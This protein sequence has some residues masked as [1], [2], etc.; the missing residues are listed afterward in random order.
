MLSATL[1]TFTL[2]FITLLL[3]QLMKLQSCIWIFNSILFLACLIQLFYVLV[4]HFN[5]DFSLYKSNCL[6]LIFFLEFFLLG[7]QF[8][9]MFI[10]IPLN[11]ILE[12]LL[13]FLR[14][15][16]SIS[17]AIE[18]IRSL[19]IVLLLSFL[20]CDPLFF[21][22]RHWLFVEFVWTLLK[23]LLSPRWF[24]FIDLFIERMIVPSHRLCIV[25]QRLLEIGLSINFFGDFLPKLWCATFL[26]YSLLI[27]Q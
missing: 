1:A 26:V 27:K 7:N 9:D 8:L 17:F 11:L 18:D 25:F 15:Y 5:C 21:S 20:T 2:L 22:V 10:H 3:I 19:W 14:S 16:F 6:V 12:M 24:T 13:G 4:K 23:K